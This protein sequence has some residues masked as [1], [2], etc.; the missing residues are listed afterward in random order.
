M[1]QQQDTIPIVRLT[2]DPPTD[3]AVLTRPYIETLL[4]DKIDELIEQDRKHISN[5][6]Q[7][8]AQFDVAKIEVH[9]RIAA[10]AEE[11]HLLSERLQTEIEKHESERIHLK[12]KLTQAQELNRITRHN[13]VKY[14]V[15]MT[16]MIILAIAILLHLAF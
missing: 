16:A 6:A 14:T 7:L 11:I 10:L 5:M 15:I 12:D 9:N 2:D 3:D 1:V 4:R 13:D 8:F